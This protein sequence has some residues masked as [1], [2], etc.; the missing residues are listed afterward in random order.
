MLH[1]D[2]HV[3]HHMVLLVQFA[4]GLA[5]RQLQQGNLRRNHPAEHIPEQWVI[6]K[7][8][9]VLKNRQQGTVDG[10]EMEKQT[11]V[12]MDDRWKKKRGTRYRI[13]R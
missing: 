11:K 9:D 7:W 2:Q 8:N 3:L 10:N 12:Y 6:P 1:G 4:D 5:L 13:R